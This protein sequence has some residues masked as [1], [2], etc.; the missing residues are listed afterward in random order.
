M[1]ELAILASRT[2]TGPCHVDFFN[3]SRERK[4]KADTEPQLRL[5]P[6]EIDEIEHA[7]ASGHRAPDLDA[8]CRRYEVALA[9]G[10]IKGRADIK[11][12]PGEAVETEPLVVPKIARLHAD[13]YVRHGLCGKRHSRCE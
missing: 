4:S 1:L 12:L 5:V 6:L 8:P 2:R 13:K 3:R 11:R 9:K 7:R 10:R